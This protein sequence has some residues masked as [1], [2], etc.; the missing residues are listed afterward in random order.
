LHVRFCPACE[1]K[2]SKKMIPLKRLRVMH[3]AAV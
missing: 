3:R 2:K 1:E